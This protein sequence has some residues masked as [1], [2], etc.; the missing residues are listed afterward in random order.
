[1]DATFLSTSSPTPD[2]LLAGEMPR[3]TKAITLLSGENRTRG[4][5]MGQIT[6][7]TG[8]GAAAAGNTGNGTIGAITIGAN[9]K[10]G[11]YRLVCIEPATN[12]GKFSVEDPDGVNVGVATVAVAFA[13]PIGF[14]I[15][16]GAT[17]FVSGDA[18]DVTVAAGSGKYKRAVAAATDG[19]QRPVGIL[20][21]DTDATAGDKA[22]AIYATGEFNEAALNFGAGHDANSV[23]AAL[24]ALNIYLKTVLAA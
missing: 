19:S 4:A 11:V 7:G 22:A 8:S 21:E 3:V 23:R 14:T 18:F 1:M 5:V 2:A 6:V 24:E 12:A 10:S 9:A 20:V 17:D 13:G 16:D 15:A